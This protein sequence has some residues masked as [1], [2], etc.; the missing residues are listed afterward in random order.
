MNVN[1]GFR[2]VAVTETGERIGFD[3]CFSPDCGMHLS[4]CR[5]DDGPTPPRLGPSAGVVRVE[6]QSPATAA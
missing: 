5:C 6:P 4:R 1:D 2:R 3:M